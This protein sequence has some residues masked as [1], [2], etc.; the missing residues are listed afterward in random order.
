VVLL[1]G[2]W[3]WGKQPFFTVKKNKNIT[4]YSEELWTRM[5]SLDK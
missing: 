1:L 2:C 5:D 3:A 4:K